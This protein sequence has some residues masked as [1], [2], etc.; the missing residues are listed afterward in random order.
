MKTCLGTVQLLPVHR[1][2]KR[3]KSLQSARPHSPVG[4][5]EAVSRCVGLE[6]P[7]VDGRR[8]AAAPGN[9][10]AAPFYT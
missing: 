4:N 7:D 2:M 1:G 10:A 5:K 3:Q 8:R 6:G 9:M